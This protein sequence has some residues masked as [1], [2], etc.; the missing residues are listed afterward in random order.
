MFYFILEITPCSG[1]LY[2]FPAGLKVQL[3]LDKLEIL[4]SLPRNVQ[5]PGVM[6]RQL[7]TLVP[8]PEDLDLIPTIHQGAHNHS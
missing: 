2:P 4:S 3:Y 5:G 8:L 1:L 7:S 6:A